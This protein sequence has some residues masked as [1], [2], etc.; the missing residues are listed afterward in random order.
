MQPVSA[1]AEE[2]RFGFGSEYWIACALRMFGDT[3]LVYFRRGQVLVG[4]KLWSYGC[5][6]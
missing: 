6:R 1:R 3:G 4:N 2:Y 5:F